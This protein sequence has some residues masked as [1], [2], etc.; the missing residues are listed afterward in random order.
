MTRTSTLTGVA[1]V[2]TLLGAPAVAEDLN[3][4]RQKIEL[5]A[6]PFVHPH[7]QVATGGPKIYEVRLVAE[8]KQMVI[9]GDGTTL[10]AMTFNGTIPA[11][12]IVIHEGDYLEVTLASLASNTMPHNI[13]FHAA[14]GAQGGGDLTLVSPGEQAVFRWKATRTGVFIYHCIPGGPM[15]PWHIASGMS[16]V[17]MVLP[18]DGLKDGKG[19]PLHY[20]RVYY[21]GEQDF[22]VPRDEKGKFKTYAS[23]ADAFADTLDTMHKLVPSHVVFNGRVDALTGKDALVAKVGENVLFIHSQADRDSRIH[24]VGG[25]GDYVWETGKFSNP[26]QTDGETWFVRGGSAAAVLYRF[27][28]PGIYPY[29]NHNMTEALELGAFA[30]IKVEGKWD[31]TLMSQVKAPAPIMTAAVAAPVATAPEAAKA[32]PGK[33]AAGTTRDAGP[34]SAPGGPVQVAATA[35]AAGGAPA[36]DKLARAAPKRHAHRRAPPPAQQAEDPPLWKSWLQKI[37]IMARNNTPADAN[38][39]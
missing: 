25:H 12:A 26:P 20:D 4:P 22:Y 36:A 31:N 21:I 28:E 24:I 34:T 27:L 33:S 8:E 19:K 39:Q 32:M 10:Q 35:A 17:V 11:P 29:V 14:T 3:L 16:G 38:R 15:I 23:H 1:V 9:D 5:V 37:G 7:E 6:P 13:D 2:V 18:R 30:H